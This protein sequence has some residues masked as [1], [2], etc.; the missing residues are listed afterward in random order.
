MTDVFYEVVIDQR[1][2]DGSISPMTYAICTTL[3][4]ARRVIQTHIGALTAD[5]DFGDGIR[6][7]RW[8]ANGEREP[9]ESNPT[10]VA[11]ARWAIGRKSGGGAVR[12]LLEDT[13]GLANVW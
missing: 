12:A 1:G 5:A 3:E 10:I 2:Y 4:H 11:E 6:I 8:R 7:F 13:L 9:S